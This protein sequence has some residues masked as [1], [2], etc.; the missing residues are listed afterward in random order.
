MSLIDDARTAKKMGLTYGQYM[1]R[2]EQ[3][4]IPPKKILHPCANCGKELPF[5]R[6]KYC[7]DACGAE[8]QIKNGKSGGN[9]V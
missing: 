8:M 5:R 3:K 6:R 9:Y 1:I 2:K 4:A 7:C